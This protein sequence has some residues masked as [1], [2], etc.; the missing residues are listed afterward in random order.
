MKRWRSFIMGVLS[1]SLLVLSCEESSS[2]EEDERKASLRETASVGESRDGQVNR[3]QSP[4]AETGKA[5]FDDG[6]LLLVRAASKEMSTGEFSI[7]WTKF[8]GKIESLSRSELSDFLDS[9]DPENP[10]HESLL[11]VGYAALAKFEPKKSLDFYVE[12]IKESKG[13]RG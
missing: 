2:S 10:D 3:R 13:G 7:Y 6:A 4:T 11:C 1:A 5:L 9:V 12:R 8:S